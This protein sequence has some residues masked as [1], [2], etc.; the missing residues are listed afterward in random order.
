MK[1]MCKICGY[2]HEGEKPPE[3]CPMCGAPKPEFKKVP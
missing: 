3:E 2:I 1:W